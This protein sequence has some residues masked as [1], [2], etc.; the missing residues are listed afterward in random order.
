MPADRLPDTPGPRTSHEARIDL[1]RA[2]HMLPDDYRMILVLHDVE[3]M[4][5]HEIAERLEI[6]VGTTKSQL[7]RAR[8][9]L[10]QW[11]SEKTE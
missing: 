8:R 3:G 6:P 9:M 2:M 7:F 4:K 11:L 5:H 10:R 1:E